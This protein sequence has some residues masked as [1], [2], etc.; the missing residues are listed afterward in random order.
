[1]SDRSPI[2]VLKQEGRQS[3]ACARAFD[4]EQLWLLDLGTQLAEADGRLL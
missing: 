3:A 2:T 4:G 1:V